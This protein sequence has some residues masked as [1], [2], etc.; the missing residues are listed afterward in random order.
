MSGESLFITYVYGF[1]I[2]AVSM[3]IIYM[4]KVFRSNG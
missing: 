1:E 4:N 2:N 3:V